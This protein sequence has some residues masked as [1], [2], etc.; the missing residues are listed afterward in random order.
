MC[1]VAVA[2]GVSRHY[3]LLLAANRDERHARASRAA[4]WWVDA[5]GVLGGRDLVAGG[6]WLG[7][8]ES[9][10]VAAVT[11]VFESTRATAP[12]SRGDL[13]TGFLTGAG[14]LPDYVA[15]ISER[16]GEYGPFNLLLY[17]AGELFLVSNRNSS[18]RLPAGVH[19]Y[20]NNP[21]GE[22]WPKVAAVGDRLAGH[23]E[24]PDPTEA[25]LA[26]LSSERSP[27]TNGDVPGSIFVVG[28]QFGTRCSTVLLIDHDGHAKFAERQFD[29]AGRSTGVVAF[30]FALAS[31]R[32][33]SRSP[34]SSR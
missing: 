7:V 1:I 31:G 9:G 11:N 2:H 34:S 28:Q 10:R 25:L 17:E 16:A 21:P 22:V 23:L 30:E 3:R 5:P 26:M 24:D 4:G 27:A 20:S 19:A 14:S 33:A 8:A 32:R 15:G 18:M 12:R 29:A 6:S 13:V